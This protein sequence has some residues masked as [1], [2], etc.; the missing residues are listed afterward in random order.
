MS[1]VNELI[2]AQI[3]DKTTKEIVIFLR[4]RAEDLMTTD[5]LAHF[6]E[7]IAL[8]EAAVMIENGMWKQ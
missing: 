1:V 3:K 7:C 2:T 4:E 6:R 8:T 5:R